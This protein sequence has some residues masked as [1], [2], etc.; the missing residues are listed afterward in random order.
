A[1]EV[2]RVVCGVTASLA[3]TMVLISLKGGY[4]VDLLSYLFGSI[5]T[6]TRSDLFYIALLGTLIILA[7]LKN[8]RALFLASLSEELAATSGIAVERVNLLLILMTSLFVSVAMQVV[9]ILLISG[10]LVIPVVTAMLWEQDFRKTLLAAISFSLFSVLTGLL[11]S[12]WFN[13]ASGGAIILVACLLLVISL[14]GR[15]VHLL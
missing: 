9:G 13:I 10:L 6:V 11:L 12:Y 1:P 2:A 5:T 14:A 15:R 8:Y 3:L 7:V 4:K